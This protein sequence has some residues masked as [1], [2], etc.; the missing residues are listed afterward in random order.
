MAMFQLLGQHQGSN[1]APLS[2]EVQVLATINESRKQPCQCSFGPGRM[3]SMPLCTRHACLLS[4]HQFV[5]VGWDTTRP[6]I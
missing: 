5:T 1:E 6:Y 4:L 2:T 3:A